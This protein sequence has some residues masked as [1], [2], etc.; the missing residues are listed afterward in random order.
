MRFF[1][2]EC[3]GKRSNSRVPVSHVKC[4]RHHTEL[5]LRLSCRRRDLHDGRGY[6]RDTGGV[7]DLASWRAGF[8]MGGFMEID[9][10]WHVIR[11]WTF[12]LDLNVTTSRSLGCCG[13]CCTISVCRSRPP[14][15]P[16]LLH[17]VHACSCSLDCLKRADAGPSIDTVVDLSGSASRTCDKHVNLFCQRNSYNVKIMSITTERRIRSARKHHVKPL[18]QKSS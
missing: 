1:V 8:V 11:F 13:S 17:S 18:P 10:G 14:A 15:Q 2:R 7:A 9:P 12:Q 16:S 4:Y 5:Y 6:R 3:R